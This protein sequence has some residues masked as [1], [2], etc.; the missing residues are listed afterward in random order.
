[1]RVPQRNLDQLAGD[2]YTVVEDF[3]A[4]ALLADAQAALWQIYPRPEEYF[5]APDQYPNL[6][7]SQFAGLRLF[8]YPSWHLNRLATHADLVDA[9]ERFLGTSQLEIY[10][11]EL[12][13]KYAGAIDYDQ[14]HHRDYGNHSLVVPSADGRGQQLTSFIL[15]SD[16]T[17]ADAPTKIVPLSRARDI[18]FVPRELPFG[19][20]FDIEVPILGRA[21]SLMMY[22]TDI[23]HRGSNFTA[24]GHSRF[25]MLVDIQAC[26]WSWAGKMAW[27]NQALKPSWDEAIT[28]MTP[29]QRMLFGFPPV[30]HDYWQ[31][32][33][34]RDTQA[35]YPAMDM[36][37]YRIAW[38]ARR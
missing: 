15:L 14:P 4:P 1:M 9:A 17:A 32:Q 11:V 33:T 28:R 38:A 35:R 31:A 10:K 21:G 34:L 26:G 18:P 3:I 13:A 25:A 37:P 16:V 2:G 6:R 36:T 24:A 19:E 27:P 29:A 30:D 23:L 7:N 5:A 12:W 20:L 22:R 8:P